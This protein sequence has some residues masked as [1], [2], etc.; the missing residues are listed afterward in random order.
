[1]KATGLVRKI[2][3]LGRVVIPAEIR[4]IMGI[5]EKNPIEIYTE[6]DKIILRKYEPTCT[7]CG[8]T[9][10]VQSYQGKIV[11][12]KCVQEVFDNV[13]AV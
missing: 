13:K 10:D 9:I 4:R 11:C 12:R 1:M 3:D 7:F 5:D 8:T 2:D 6:F